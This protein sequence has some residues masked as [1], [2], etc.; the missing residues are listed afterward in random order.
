MRLGMD[1]YL[2]ELEGNG[3]SPAPDPT[4]GVYNPDTLEQARTFKLQ[5]SFASDIRSIAVDASGN[6]YAAEW[7]GTLNKY[8]SKGNTTT[9]SL[10]LKDQD[11]FGDN[12]MNV[13][14][15]TDGQIAVGGRSGAI[16]LTNES[17]A[18]YKRID[19]AQWNVFVTFNHY[20]GTATV[21]PTFSALAGPTIT[22]GQAT[23]TLGGTITVG[24][25]IPGG[26]VNITLAGVTKSAAISP[27]D[28][29]FSSVFDTSTLS[30]SGSPYPIT[31][32]YPGESHASA[33][34]DTSKSL[35]VNQAA[36]SL[37]NLSSPTV[38]TGTSSV[39]LS[40]LVNSNSVLP[41]G[42]SVSVTVLDKNNGTVASGQAVIGSKGAFSSGVDVSTLPVGAYTILY[43]YAGDANFVASSGAGK[44]TVTY[45]VTA[46]FD[47]TKGHHPGSTVPIKIDVNDASGGA[48]PGLQ[49][50]A[51][52]LVNAQ[53]QSFPLDSRRKGGDA[54][55]AAGSHYQYNLDSTGLAHG[56]Y[57]LYV[58]VG[59]DPVLHGITF[60]IA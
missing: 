22:Y 9:T 23:A 51:V 26:N 20:I 6:V 21:T 30:V 11:G 14:I 52:S 15:D 25:A 34:K 46:L 57:T 40:G 33:I 45:D 10:A 17:L 50:T 42:Q 29:S 39:M 16:Y 44:L 59:D 12:L 3:N 38:L 56:T 7:G 60:V 4:I 24:A 32:S 37:T 53:G 27:T 41:V 8:D 2:Y 54:F 55:K 28:G 58:R 36:T 49:V 43:A 1:G 18:A 31:Y 47:T 48:E 19:T 35:T 5:T 13:A